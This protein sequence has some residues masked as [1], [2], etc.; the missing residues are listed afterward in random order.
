MDS[1]DVVIIG[2]GQAG[3][4]LAHELA[5]Q[6]KRTALIERKHLGGSC[7][8]FGCTPTKAAI[9]SARVAHLARRGAEFGLR[10]PSVEIDFGKVIQRAR[11]IVT[12]SRSGIERGLQGKDNPRWIRGHGRVDGREGDRFRVVV[13]ETFVLASHVVLDTGTRSAMPPIEGL[14]D[15]DVIDSGNW[16]ERDTQPQRVIVIGGGVIA[17]EMA[18]F[19]RRLGSDVVVIESQPQIAGSEDHDV[20]EALQELLEREGIEFH[21]EAKIERVEKSGGGVMVHIAEKGT[22]VGSDLFVAAGRKPNTDDLG[23]DTVGVTVERGIVTVNERLQTN[24]TGIW[25]AGDIRG[26]PMFTHTAWDDYRVLV[27]QLAGDG[28]RTTAERIVPYAIFTDPEVG[29]VGMTERQ[30]RGSGKKIKVVRFEISRNA[31]SVEIGETDGFIKLI[32]D[33]ESDQLL[34]ATVLC[35]EAAE[36]VHIYID[37][38]NNR[39]PL[40]IIRDAVYIHPTLAEAVQS[41]VTMP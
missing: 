9:T 38:M 22:I 30:A 1:F 16:L 20:A 29:R 10:I 19:Y 6:G 31:K 21:T 26:G 24:V 8:N 5:E 28:S 17:L 18:Q 32:A 2:A 14:R 23:L 25:A 15:I 11:D 27:S 33:A 7:I 13:G 4:P 3:V 37:L 36:L 40:S 39:A 41:A 12:A 35:H 34:G